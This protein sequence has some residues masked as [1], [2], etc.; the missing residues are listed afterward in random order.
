MNYIMKFLIIAIVISCVFG[1][2][3]VAVFH[4]IGDS[5]SNSGM[6][7]ITSYFSKS[8]G[9]V[10][11]KC[12]ETGGGILDF[13]TSFTS[14]SKLACDQIKNDPNFKG[15][16]SVVGISQGSLIARYIIQACDMQGRVKRYVSIGGPQMGVAKLP[17]CESGII[18]NFINSITNKLVYSSYIQNFVGPAGYFKDVH[19]YQDYLKYSSFLAD[20]NNENKINVDYK[21]RFQNL[22]KIAL[23]K[24]TEDTMII[25][26]QTAW[27]QFFNEKE[28]V[29][30]FKETDLYKNDYIGFK[31][32]VE[33]SKVNFVALEGNHLAFD[34]DD[35]KEHAIPIL[36]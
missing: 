1:S 14:Q 3:P 19:N 8:L 31:S 18:C 28:E 7:H 23:I 6:N 2:Y 25:P 22:E 26:G 34:Y 36:Q 16:F 29:I 24:F 9:G 20:L 10:Y 32:L 15:D 27:F 33:Q 12:I 35:L 17:H 5:C 4:G 13:T 11:S 30:D 21:K